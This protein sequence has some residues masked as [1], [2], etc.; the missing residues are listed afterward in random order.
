[1]GAQQL[2]DPQPVAQMP[3]K[4]GADSGQAHEWQFRHRKEGGVKHPHVG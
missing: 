4:F 1:V 3:G 2:A